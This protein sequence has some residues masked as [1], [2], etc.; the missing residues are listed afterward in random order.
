MSQN[1]STET[2]DD[3]KSF[4]EW[5]EQYQLISDFDTTET[6]RQAYLAG[7]RHGY[8]KAFTVEQPE[9]IKI[10]IKP[11]RVRAAKRVCKACGEGC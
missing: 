6:M 10:E 4:Y 1:Q 8:S 5:W 11:A 7:M 3:N 2:E 9:P